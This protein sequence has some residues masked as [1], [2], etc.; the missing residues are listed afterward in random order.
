[1]KCIHC[2]TEL[3]AGEEFYLSCGFG[4]FCDYHGEK[5]QSLDDRVSRDN[6]EWET[7]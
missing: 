1:M 6:K 7:E 4:P 5:M 2:G 3:E